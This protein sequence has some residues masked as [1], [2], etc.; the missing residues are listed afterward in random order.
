MKQVTTTA[1][2]T[3]CLSG[4]LTNKLEA[5]ARAGFD[6]VEV[7]A[8]DLQSSGLAPRTVGERCR[9]L[10]L[11]VVALQ[12]FRDAEALPPLI[13]TTSGTPSLASAGSAEKRS[14]ELAMR[15]LV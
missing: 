1:M 2:A 5:I 4:E 3:L 6:G 10:G 13:S 15:P 9:E 8:D 11:T 14:S 12:P 7:F